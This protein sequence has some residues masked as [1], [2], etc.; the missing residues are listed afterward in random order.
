MGRFR[1]QGCE[2]SIETGGRRAVE[3]QL[4]AGDRMLEAQAAG[5]E[6]EA[7]EARQ[8]LGQRRARA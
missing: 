6:R 8:M 3:A 5:M 2:Q 4:R 7:V 1:L